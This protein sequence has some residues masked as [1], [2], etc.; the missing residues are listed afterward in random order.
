MEESRNVVLLIMFASVC[1]FLAFLST[2]TVLFVEG[3]Q[4]QGFSYW[5]S[6]SAFIQVAPDVPQLELGNATHPGCERDMPRAL[7]RFAL[8]SLA[9][10]MLGK[11]YLK[12]K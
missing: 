10:F 1:G 3:E 11:K 8:V 6:S 7:I 4:A 9:I 12:K 5:C 2:P